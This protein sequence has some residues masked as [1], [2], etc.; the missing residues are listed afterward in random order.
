[1]VT[2]DD[3]GTH[4]GILMTPVIEGGDVKEP[5]QNRVLV[6]VTAEDVLKPGTADILFH[7]TRR[8]TNS[9]VTCWKQTPLTP[10]KCVPLYPATP[11]P[12]AVPAMVDSARTQHHQQR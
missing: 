11:T 4:E 7:A 12:R 3:C 2:E 5:L 1:M 10:L 6:V 8:C 9:G